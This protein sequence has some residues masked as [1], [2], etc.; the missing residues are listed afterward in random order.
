MKEEQMKM[1]LRKKKEKRKRMHE[2]KVKEM[3]R[4]LLGG[5]DELFSPVLIMRVC[6]LTAEILGHLSRR[7][8]GLADIA[9]VS[10]KVN[11]LS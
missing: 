4:Y 6:V 2:N 3:R 1:K 9:K 7:E 8:L 11:C 10:G 5:E